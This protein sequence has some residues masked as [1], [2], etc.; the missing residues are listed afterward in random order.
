MN[1]EISFSSKVMDD[2]KKNRKRNKLILYG[3]LGIIASAI[4][5]IVYFKVNA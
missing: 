4:L 3:T 1:T 2:I 5:I